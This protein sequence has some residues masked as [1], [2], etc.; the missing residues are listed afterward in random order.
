MNFLSKKYTALIKMCIS[1]YLPKM[2]SGIQVQSFNL[3]LILI[4]VCR[5]KVDLDRSLQD[6]G[7]AKKNSSRKKEEEDDEL[8]LA[9]LMSMG[10]DESMAKKTVR[11]SQNNMKTAL[12]WLTGQGEP[13]ER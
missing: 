7:L 10:V 4:G 3:C 9:T 8:S 13:E 1:R 2:W 12:L 6:Q 11:H 5:S